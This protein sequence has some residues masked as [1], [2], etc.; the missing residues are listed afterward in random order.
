MKVII[1]GAGKVGSSVAE[2]LVSEQNDITVI[3]TNP[4][5][6]AL[7]QER[8]DL[9]VITGSGTH[10]SVLEAAGAHDADMLIA[11]TASDEANLVACKVG[12]QVFNIPQRI[13]RIRSNEFI[14]QPELIGAEGFGIDHLINPERS[15]TTYLHRLIQFPAALQVVDFADGQV[16]LALVHIAP[17]SPLV[18]LSALAVTE[19]LPE[20]NGHILA[21]FRNDRP[22]LI[23][24]QSVIEAG[25]E[26]LFL[27]ET[28]HARKAFQEM[29]QTRKTARRIMIAGGGNIGQRLALALA[30]DHYSVKIID[31]SLER[32]EFLSAHTPGNVLVLHGDATDEGLLE[33]ENVEGADVFLALTS[34]DENN[35]MAALLAKRMGAHRVMALIGRRSYGELMEGSR[36]DVAV[37]PDQA[38]IGELL[39]YVRRGDV[40]AVHKF[41]RGS[42]EALEAVAHGDKASS[43]VVGRRLSQ[44][45]LPA[46]ASIGAVVRAEQILMPHQDP[47]IEA[48]DHLIVLV[49]RRRLIPKVEQ[50]FQVSAAFF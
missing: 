42:V 23:Q 19:H 33:D 30:A 11:C 48:E 46:G 1:L 15:V 26:V 47:V 43:R 25:D 5:P 3:D 21:I 41:K 4:A 40:V 10:I 9:R 37:A 24:P 18:H 20:V 28:R 32:C 2:N 6:L 31:Q 17:N 39:R 14:D 49:T 35:I 22:I 36:I 38:T 50:L 16:T 45:K 12:R 8:L 7:L 44:L 27:V 34:D 13:A 29:Q